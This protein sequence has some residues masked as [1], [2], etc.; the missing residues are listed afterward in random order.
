MRRRL[1]ETEIKELK[2]VFHELVR[3]SNSGAII[4]VEGPSDRDSLR[5]LGIKGEIYL[6]S[7][8]PDVNLVDSIARD[9]EVI[10][11]SDWDTEGRKIVRR[12]EKL[13]S[14]RGIVVNTEFRKRIF[15]VVGREIRGIEN[16]S[17]YLEMLSQV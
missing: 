6:A 15:R 3:A 17:R 1:S 4:I 7:T 9:A 2:T 10:I 16:L 13:L 5:S 14:S 12:L 8:Q 11:L